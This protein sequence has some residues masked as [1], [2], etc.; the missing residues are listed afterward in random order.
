MTTPNHRAAAPAPASAALTEAALAQHRASVSATER[1]GVLDNF[2][3]RTRIG[4]FRAP[5]PTFFRS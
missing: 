2:T 1:A 4:E 5:S 3:A